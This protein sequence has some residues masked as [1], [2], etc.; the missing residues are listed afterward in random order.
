MH[1]TCCKARY[2]QKHSCNTTTTTTSGIPRSSLKTS[3]PA[4]ECTEIIKEKNDDIS[5]FGSILQFQV[6]AAVYAF[7]AYIIKDLFKSCIQKTQQSSCFS[8]KSDGMLSF[9]TCLMTCP[10][11]KYYF[12]L[13]V[14]YLVLIQVVTAVLLWRD[15]ERAAK[16]Q[17]RIWPSTHWLIAFAGGIPTA[18]LLMNILRFKI[19]VPKYYYTALFLTLFNLLWPIFYLMY[20]LN[21]K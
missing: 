21:H 10:C 12:N 1:Q 7:L 3:P 8:G 18:W 5:F 17:Y 20:Y 4:G 11:S 14:V 16:Q 2:N 9:K 19:C 13:L 6:I 15:R